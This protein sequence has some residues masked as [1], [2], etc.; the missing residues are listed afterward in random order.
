MEDMGKNFVKAILPV[1]KKEF[2]GQIFKDLISALYLQSFDDV[3]TEKILISVYDNL[4]SHTINREQVFIQNDE[5]RN[6]PNPKITTGTDNLKGFLVKNCDKHLAMRV[7][8]KVNTI[9]VPSIDKVNELKLALGSDNFIVMDNMNKEVVHQSVVSM[10]NGDSMVNET[11]VLF[12]YPIKI[13][14]HNNPIS[15]AGRTFS[16]VW[17]TKSH[18][19]FATNNMTLSEI[20][21]QLTEQGYVLQKRYVSTA[22]TAILHIAEA[23]DLLICKNEIENRGFYLDMETNELIKIGYEI[24]PLDKEKIMEGLLLIEDLAEYFKGNE[25]KLATTLKHGLIAPFGFAKKQLG[26]PLE[27]LIPYLYHYGKAESGKTTIARIGLWFYDKPDTNTNDIGG[28]EFDTVPR[29]GE[30]LKKFTFGIVVNEPESS[31]EKR[32][33]AS[34]LKSSMERTNS[35]QKISGNRMEH[36]LALA[37]VSFASNIPLPNVEGLPRRFVQ[38]LY[39]HNE[40]KSL[41]EKEEFMEHFMLNNP[42]ECKFNKL[43]AL[44]NF[45]VAQIDEDIDL[46]QED[47]KTLGNTIIKRAYEYVDCEV[48][49]WLLEYVESITDEDLE[50]DEIENIRMLFINEINRQSK[51]INLYNISDADLYSRVRSVIENGYIPYMHYKETNGVEE[52]CFTNGLKKVMLDNDIPCFNVESTA[53]L[54]GWE[55]KQTWVNKKNSRCMKV[56][57]NEFIKFLYPYW[58]EEED[59][60]PL[61]SP[62]L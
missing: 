31:F 29:I 52:I 49:E 7:M 21:H 44:G 8:R 15:D 12:C 39:T 60:N 36:I 54:L 53:Q 30:Q 47:W 59:D 20:E 13:I 57:I 50:T 27:Y 43:Q 17:E 6:S 51:Q 23:H 18:K 28:T 1:Y 22:I 3:E 16:I 11:K 61:Y 56:D 32:S 19:H 58:E 40:K 2:E 38:L 42:S 37:M 45:A 10:K 55:Y 46:L 26:L 41:E 5:I 9:L 48:P 62:K 33:C 35:R 24:E 4:P 25:A 34:T 14:E